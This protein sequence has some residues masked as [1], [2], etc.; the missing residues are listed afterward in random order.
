MIA[1][2]KYVLVV[3]SVSHPAQ[4]LILDEE[5]KILQSVKLFRNFLYL[6]ETSIVLTSAPVLLLINALLFAAWP[7]F[8]EFSLHP[9]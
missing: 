8:M 2:L 4:K 9:T 7:S 1:A 5:T 6:K 3:F